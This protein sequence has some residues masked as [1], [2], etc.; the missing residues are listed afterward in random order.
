MTAV[1]DV[2]DACGRV[3]GQKVVALNVAVVSEQIAESIEVEIVRIAKTMRDRLHFSALRR[4]TDQRPGLD[5]PDR[6]PGAGDKLRAEPRVISADQIEPA[7]GSFANRMAAMFARAN[8]KKAFRR[9]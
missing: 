3:P 2:I 8:S 4:E 7:I 6:W 1:S 5:V 9:P